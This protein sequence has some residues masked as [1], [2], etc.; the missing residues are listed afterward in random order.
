MK[1]YILL[2]FSILFFFAHSGD[3]YANETI[4]VP[5]IQDTFVDSIRFYHDHSEFSKILVG[6][7]STSKNG[8]GIT[9]LKY[10][11]EGLRGLVGNG[12]RTLEDI[13]L[14]EL[15]MYQYRNRYMTPFDVIVTQ[16]KSN[17]EENTVSWINMP[18]LDSAFSRTQRIEPVFGWSSLDITELFL[19]QYS[20][21]EESFGLV[22]KNIDDEGHGG[23]FWS[24]DCLV[25]QEVP[26]CTQPLFP[27]I[28][29]ILKEKDEGEQ[30]E[31]MPIVEEGEGGDVEGGEDEDYVDDAEGLGEDEVVEKDEK[32]IEEKAEQMGQGVQESLSPKTP[33]HEKVGESALDIEVFGSNG[34]T[35]GQ[36]E[37]GEVLGTKT[38]NEDLGYCRYRYNITLETIV[39]ERCRMKRPIVSRIDHPPAE[40][41]YWIDAEIIV[42][43]GLEMYVQVVQCKKWKLFDLQTWFGKCS[44]EVVEEYSE[45]IFGEIRII[46]ASSGKQINLFQRELE[47]G[48]IKVS[49][50][51]DEDMSAK[52]FTTRYIVDYSAK[53]PRD[54]KLFMFYEVSPISDKVRIPQLRLVS[55]ADSKP[56]IFP[57]SRNIGVTQWY[58]KTEFQNPHTGID[59]GAKKEP[60]LAVGD[61]RVVYV[62]WDSGKN[63]CLSG[64]NYVLVEHSG[65]MH[66]IYLHLDSF[67][68]KS[69]INLTV[70]DRVYKGQQIGVSG[71]SGLYNCEPLGYHLHFETRKNREYESHTNPVPLIN[72]DWSKVS[73]LGFVQNPGRLSGENPH[74]GK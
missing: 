25:S 7:G 10:D 40:R 43:D 16:P 34:N 5:I 1:K 31:D 6:F 57:F 37:S 36:N 52:Y 50:P 38:G 59:F 55:S 2:I 68:D 8:T 70:G 60:V 33:E 41:I 22:V 56:F 64:G 42:P 19:L 17:W 47:N 53:V 13:E 26:N 46:N 4:T 66:T 58:G 72:T 21:W 65:G 35:V 48:N 15:R 23:D 54:G 3:A 63:K 62:G 12:E 71:N 74:P 30:E 39:R 27:H 9:L 29:V 11:I 67:K 14:V 73:T 28:L 45:R 49:L 69:G 61:G 44:E 24:I 18:E 32:K 51:V 20:N